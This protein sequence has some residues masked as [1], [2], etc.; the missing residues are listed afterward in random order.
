MNDFTPTARSR[1]RRM[2]KRGHYDRAT[3]HA[4]LDA[5]LQCHVGY[6]IDGHPYVTPTAYWR[7]GERIYWHGSSASRML[8]TVS[9]G[10]PVCFTVSLMDGLVVARSGFH[11]SINYRSVMVF[12][13]AHKIEAREDKLAALTAFTERLYPGRWDAIRPPTEQEVKATMVLSMP[14][15]EAV[16][17]I[18]TGPPIDDEEDYALPYWAGVVKLKTV[19]AGLEADPRLAPG[20]APGADLADYVS[21]T[22]FNA[23]LQAL[24][25]SAPPLT[26]TLSPSGGEGSTC[27]LQQ[28]RPSPR[29][30]WRG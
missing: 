28:R 12:G 5:G 29:E 30:A 22:D 27:A 9:G 2:P 16:A 10:V 19:V 15:D 3:V 18:R 1:V 4:V 21:G 11:H 7:E 14:L 23:L 25:Q 26:P 17:K 8:R 13:T 20:I 6:V 24:A